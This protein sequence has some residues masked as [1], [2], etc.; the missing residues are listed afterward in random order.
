MQKEREEEA[1]RK[2]TD[3]KEAKKVQGMAANDV[4]VSQQVPLLNQR[5]RGSRTKRSMLL[6]GKVDGVRKQAVAS[7]FGSSKP[8]RSDSR[9]RTS[10]PGSLSQTQLHAQLT[11][12]MA[13]T[14]KSGQVHMQSSRTSAQW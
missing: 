13:R 5:L 1:I 11:S 3:D 10:C 12:P 14:I 2:E 4:V 8:T 7:T 9:P 6:S